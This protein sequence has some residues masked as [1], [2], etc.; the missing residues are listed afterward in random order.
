MLVAVADPATIL[1]RHF[2]VLAVATTCNALGGAD[3]LP[4]T[5]PQLA[6]KRRKL[7]RWRWRKRRLGCATAVVVEADNGGGCYG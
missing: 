6:H 5:R 1:L 7:G 2:R 4:L 3:G